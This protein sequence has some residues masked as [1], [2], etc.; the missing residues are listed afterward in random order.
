VTLSIVGAGLWR[1]GTLS[2]KRAIEEL[3]LGP[4]FHVLDSTSHSAEHVSRAY[5]AGSP[6]WDDIFVGYRAAVDMPA[7]LFYGQLAAR[8][9]HAKVILTVR[10]PGDW[11]RSTQQLGQLLHSRAPPD[12]S[13]QSLELDERMLSGV[14]GEYLAQAYAFRDYDSATDAFKHYNAQVQ[15]SIAPERLLVFDVKQGWRALCE[16]LAVP[17]PGT[18]FPHANSRAELPSLLD[19]LNKVHAGER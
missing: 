3:G 11:Y 9:P 18:P 5:I 13:R 12:T 19:R 6:D 1:T 16:F 2:L 4:C 14:F 7:S 8:Y 15:R 10:D 17:I